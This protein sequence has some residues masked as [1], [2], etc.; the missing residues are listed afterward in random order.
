MAKDRATWRATLQR[1]FEDLKLEDTC[2]R[3]LNPRTQILLDVTVAVT[4]LSPTLV[5]PAM[6]TT[7]LDGALLKAHNW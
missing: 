1:G 3:K 7:E 5:E 2:S 6:R 4:V